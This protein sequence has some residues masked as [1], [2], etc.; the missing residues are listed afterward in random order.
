MFEDIYEIIAFSLFLF[1]A[2]LT[3]L[4]I[5]LDR[6]EKAKERKFDHEIAR[7]PGMQFYQPQS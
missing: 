7:C 4:S 5:V 1:F 6:R 2:N 3:V